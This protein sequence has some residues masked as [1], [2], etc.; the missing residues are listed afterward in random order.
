MV[1]VTEAVQGFCISA[2]GAADWLLNKT[3]SS[4][5]APVC[6]FYDTNVGQYV[7]S[8]TRVICVS[9]GSCV[10]FYVNAGTTC[11]RFAH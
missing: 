5:H 3:V 9:S 11:A 4:G 7:K 2:A 1:N 6:C 8:D 10:P